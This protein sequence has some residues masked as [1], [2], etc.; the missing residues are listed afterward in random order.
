MVFSTALAVTMALLPLASGLQA[1]RSFGGAAVSVRG[2]SSPVVL[3]L[4]AGIPVM[5]IKTMSITMPALSST[6]K[7]GKISS[8]LMGVGDKVTSGDMV[9]VVESDKADMDVES[10]EE[11]YIAKILVA[12]GEVA[13]VGATVAL[14]VENE[15]DIAAVAAGAGAPTAATPAPAAPAPAAAAAAPASDVESVPV[16]MPALS[17]TMKEGKISSWLVGVG[18]KVEAG[19]MLL[20]VESD[21]ADMD[22]ESF[23]E[24]YVA[25]ILVA[26]GEVRP[27]YCQGI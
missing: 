6:M 20:V 2:A 19:D 23:E 12:E 5:E 8:W 21:K 9:L 10:Y 4:R 22:V 13:L 25:K 11:G 18:D 15:A 26:E 16:M 1:V 3:T 24:G 14:I 27:T 7:E 17:S